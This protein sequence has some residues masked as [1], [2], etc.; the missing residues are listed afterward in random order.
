MFNIFKKKKQELEV[1]SCVEG[2]LLP[3]KDVK[4]EV[5]SSGAI[6]RGVAVRPSSG[7]IVSPVDGM[8]RMIFPTNHAIGLETEEGLEF[9]IHV[10]IDTV[11]LKGDGFRRIA[12]EGQRVKAGDLLLEVDFAQ[13]KEKGYDTDTLILLTTG[14]DKA[15]FSEAAVYGERVGG[16]GQTIFICNGR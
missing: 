10:G 16:P 3:L 12:Q 9:L 1:I 15:D 11:K 13:L 4:D 2:I 14:E 6:G 7:R 5:F 8:I